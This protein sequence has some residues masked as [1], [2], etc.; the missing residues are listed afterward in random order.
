MA[1]NFL[2]P[3][4]EQVL[5]IHED[6]VKQF[7]GRLPVNDFT[8]LHSA[9]ERPKVTFGG[10]DLYPDIFT[11]AAA[12]ISSLILNHPFDDGNKRTALLTTMLFIELNGY[13]LTV[14]KFSDETYEFVVGID[15]K[16][17]D[18]DE[19]LEWLKMNVKK[20]K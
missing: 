15:L 1:N 20:K 2:Y 3:T 13:E 17:Y 19:F 16:K 11:K 10:Q 18:F 4:L 7:G 9:L 12:L 14:K 8:M 6:A 5:D